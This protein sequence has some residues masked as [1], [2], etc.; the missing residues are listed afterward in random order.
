VN[1]RLSGHLTRSTL[2]TIGFRLSGGLGGVL[3]ARLLG[4]SQRGQYAVL[5]VIATAVGLLGTAG[6]Q[7]WVA[8]QVARPEGDAVEPVI[9]RQLRVA[10][11]GLVPFFLCSLAVAGAFGL[12]S[13]VEVSAAALLAFATTWSMLELAVPNGLLRMGAVALITTASGATFL[14]WMGIGLAFGFSSAAY[15]VGG[16]AVA[17]LVMVPL[18]RRHRRSLPRRDQHLPVAGLH[19]RAVRVGLP[20]GAGE[21]L[22]LA[23]FRLDL[24]LVA[25]L[26][27]RSQ[28]GVYA[29]ALALS[30]LLWVIPDG[31]A[32][33]LVPHVARQPDGK[34][35]VRLVVVAGI[36]MAAGGAVMVAFSGPIITTV[37]GA[38]YGG[39]AKAL[40]ALAFAALAMGIWKMVGADVVARGNARARASSALL[41]LTSMVALDV[42]LIPRWGIT[43]AGVGAAIAYGLAAAHVCLSRHR[44]THKPGLPEPVALV[45]VT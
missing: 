2:G 42:V 28:A 10:T 22:T 3:S 43:G 36:A 44:S 38:R 6:L 39:A 32:Q 8:L 1:Q 40:P 5:V 15:A 11:L 24:V 29:V 14:V 35:T 33:V 7:F 26:L 4:P 17:N 25:A 18:A 13:P 27:T 16:A 31:V 23:T 34:D 30:E 21:L 9:G 19:R 37:F 12:A 45:G 41:G 20:A